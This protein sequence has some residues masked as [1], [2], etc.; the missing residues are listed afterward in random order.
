MDIVLLDAFKNI[1]DVQSILT[2]VMV[3]TAIVLSLD[4]TEFVRICK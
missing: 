4:Q 3:A 2:A 1:I